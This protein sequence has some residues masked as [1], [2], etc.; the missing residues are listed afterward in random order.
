MGAGRGS[1]VNRL[2]EVNADG[3]VTYR[4]VA[5]EECQLSLQVLLNQEVA[6]VMTYLSVQQVKDQTLL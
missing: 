6:S 2:G 5:T 3:G 1:F 4:S